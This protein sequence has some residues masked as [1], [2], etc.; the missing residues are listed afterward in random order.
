MIFK[1]DSSFIQLGGVANVYVGQPLDTIK[2]KMQMFP[3]LYKS[4]MKCGLETFKK[5]GF[6]KILQYNLFKSRIIN[7]NIKV[8]EDCMPEQFQ[9]CQPT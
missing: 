9:L 5:D 2:V 1:K 8:L 3:N 4:G 6:P 7:L